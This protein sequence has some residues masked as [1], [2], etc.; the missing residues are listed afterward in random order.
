MEY[1]GHITSV[2][3]L[4][5]SMFVVAEGDFFRGHS[6]MDY[7]Y[8]LF[9]AQHYGL[10]TRLLDWTYNPLVAL[11]FATVSNLDEDGC[12][13]HSFPRRM[14]YNYERKNPFTVP[15][16]TIV[17]L[18]LTNIRYRNQNGLFMVYSQPHIEDKSVSIKKY[19]IPKEYKEPIQK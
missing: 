12:L 4:L 3:Q 16:N 10:P 2:E 18:D 5:S 1:N 13:Y 8:F 6:C 17:L 19:L 14:I 11:Y 7:R 9:L 15:E